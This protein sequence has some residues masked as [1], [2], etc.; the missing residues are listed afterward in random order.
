MREIRW[1]ARGTVGKR[2]RPCTA[3]GRASDSAG[4]NGVK[5]EVKCGTPSFQGSHQPL[6]VILCLTGLFAHPAILSPK[7][8]L[9]DGGGKWCGTVG[10]WSQARHRCCCRPARS[11]RVS[12]RMQWRRGDLR[13]RRRRLDLPVQRG[14]ASIDPDV[15]PGAHIGIECGCGSIVRIFWRRLLGVRRLRRGEPVEPKGA[16]RFRRRGRRL[17]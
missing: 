1:N 7:P 2:A 10:V 4:T 5:T 15:P 11:R 12:D 17:A 16:D 13:R 3:R 8:W 9:P 6:R 14:I